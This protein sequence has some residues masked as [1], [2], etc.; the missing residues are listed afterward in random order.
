MQAF[1]HHAIRSESG[2]WI[3]P[4][5][6]LLHDTFTVNHQYVQCQNEMHSKSL[7]CDEAAAVLEHLHGLIARG[8]TQAELEAAVVRTAPIRARLVDAGVT[9]GRDEWLA[10]LD[11][12][13]AMLR[14][15]DWA[16]DG[17]TVMRE[18][19]AEYFAHLAKLDAIRSGTV[20]A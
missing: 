9:Q 13:E 1:D 20:P 10:S 8:A 6:E 4:N 17:L 19:K 3:Y 7:L 14:G 16:V 2:E 18:V 12:T 5:L 11:E 15:K